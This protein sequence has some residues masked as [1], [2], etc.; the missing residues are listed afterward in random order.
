MGAFGDRP[1]LRTIG[2]IC[3]EAGLGRLANRYRTPYNGVRRVRG[4]LGRIFAMDEAAWRAAVLVALGDVAAASR[5]TEEALRDLAV[6]MTQRTPPGI[7]AAL[8]APRQSIKR[9]MDPGARALAVVRQHERARIERLYLPIMRH[10]R[11]VG[12]IA[13][14]RDVARAIVHIGGARTRE[15]TTAMHQMASEGYVRLFEKR[16]EGSSG[17]STLYVQLSSV[18]RTVCDA[19]GDAD[20]GVVLEKA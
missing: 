10:L 14:R 5:R 8:E 12:G 6:V 7:P 11:R 2:T 20:D 16:K 4:S 13:S 19:A 17:K 15:I 18:G 9:I 3:F 1:V